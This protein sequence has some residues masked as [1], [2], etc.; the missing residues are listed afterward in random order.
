MWRNL[1]PHSFLME[2]EKDVIAHLFKNYMI[3]QL[4]CWVSIQERWKYVSNKDLYINI[5]AVS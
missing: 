5:Q 4:L 1:N 3:Q 2:I